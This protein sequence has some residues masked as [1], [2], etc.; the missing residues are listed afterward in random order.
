MEG[1]SP[2]EVHTNMILLK[3]PGGTKPGETTP[4]VTTIEIF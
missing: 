4:F 2:C 3:I 1:S